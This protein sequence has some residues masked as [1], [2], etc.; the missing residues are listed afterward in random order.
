M[1][2][3]VPIRI[4]EATNGHGNNAVKIRRTKQNGKSAADDGDWFAQSARHLHP[5]KPGTVL[6]LTTG[7]GDE[8]LCQRYAAGDVR[9]PAYFLR[10]LLRSDSGEQWLNAVMDGCTQ[11]WWVKLKTDSDYG[12]KIRAVE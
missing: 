7:L 1:S 12:R 10:S 2:I 4:V 3:S 5:H 6:F 11:A 9:P 8:R